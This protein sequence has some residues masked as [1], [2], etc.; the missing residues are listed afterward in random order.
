[1]VLPLKKFL[2]N[3]LAKSVL[4]RSGFIWVLF[5]EVSVITFP[6]VPS[7]TM[8]LKAACDG[9]LHDFISVAAQC[10]YKVTQL[11]APGTAGARGR[12]GPSSSQRPL[13]GWTE[14][15]RRASQ[16][17]LHQRAGGANAIGPQCCAW[18]PS[19]AAAGSMRPDRQPGP[20]EIPPWTA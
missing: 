17:H 13:D 15:V 8:C 6:T 16:G 20:R 18:L 1:M 11:L 12:R 3:Q 14:R 10:S 5:T 2:K 9:H 19:S 4:P 7:S